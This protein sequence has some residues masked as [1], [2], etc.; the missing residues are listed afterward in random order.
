[1]NYNSKVFIIIESKQMILLNDFTKNTE[2]SEKV[3]LYSNPKNFHSIPDDPP[4]E[5]EVYQELPP[6]CVSRITSAH[7]SIYHHSHQNIKKRQPE[8]FIQFSEITPNNIIRFLSDFNLN[9]NSLL[10]W[11]QQDVS[12]FLRHPHLGLM[13]YDILDYIWNQYCYY[14]S[15]PTT[16][17]FNGNNIDGLGLIYLFGKKKIPLLH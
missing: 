2:K 3:K 6:T 7:Q 9:T 17:C 16:R 5:S 10:D 12:K 13:S 1:M 11:S 4:Y 15:S 14:Y 8:Q